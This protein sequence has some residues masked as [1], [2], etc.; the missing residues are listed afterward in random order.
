MAFV[1]GTGPFNLG[2][3]TTGMGGLGSNRMKVVEADHF[4]ILVVEGVEAVVGVDTVEG[5]L[6]YPLD[7]DPLLKFE[8][9][10]CKPR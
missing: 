8:G 1:G 4:P 2:E 9:N 3:G 7:L 6:D 10:A 5:E